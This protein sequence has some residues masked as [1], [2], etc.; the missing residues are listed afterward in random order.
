MRRSLLVALAA[1]MVVVG[2][3]APAGAA[4]TDRGPLPAAGYSW[5][6]WPGT[7]PC[8]QNPDGST[9]YPTKLTASQLTSN[10]DCGHETPLADG[11]RFWVFCDTSFYRTD[12]RGSK[13]IADVS[14]S[15]ALEDGGG[16]LRTPLFGG[17]SPPFLDPSNTG[18]F[19][20]TC[21]VRAGQT[22]RK[23]VFPM[24]IA[25]LPHTETP[26]NTTYDDLVIFY[27]QICDWG[28]LDY[29]L[30]DVGVAQFHYTSN[31]PRLTVPPKSTAAGTQPVQASPLNANLFTKGANPD[32]T[33]EFG[34]VLA[35]DYLYL[36]RCK[37]QG[38]CTV[39]NVYAAAGTSYLATATNW[40]YLDAAGAWKN[41]PNT[42]PVG[43]VSQGFWP[44]TSDTSTQVLGV[45][46]IVKFTSGYPTT[47]YVMAYLA[48]PV[49][50][51]ALIIR[52]APSPTGPWSAPRRLSVP[53]CATGCVGPVLHPKWTKTINGATTI[54]LTYWNLNDTTITFSDNTTATI[55]R[56][57]RVDLPAS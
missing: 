3:P 49:F 55:N 33:F 30:H 10:R 25:A 9:A 51:N 36:Y 57:R 50:T 4:I 46:S 44:A 12:I 34:A 35:S 6:C 8:Y 5:N 7:T 20:A 19:N 39:A 54:G 21:S 45:P 52:T 31:D 16:T 53:K 23:A 27:Q 42:A 28:G 24:S 48:P 1:A 38:A 11:R 15:M 47:T 43:V 41:N 18:I 37:N 32:Y 17:Q 2:P 40:W 13:P 22:P 56:L 14:S 29:E 26:I